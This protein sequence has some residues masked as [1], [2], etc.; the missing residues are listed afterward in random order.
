MTTILLKDAYLCPGTPESG[1]HITD[2]SVQCSCG[3]RNLMPLKPVLDAE[4]EKSTVME[5]IM[6]LP[7]LRIRFAEGEA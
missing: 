3:S 1:E 4:T 6:S 5:E 7:S 2:S